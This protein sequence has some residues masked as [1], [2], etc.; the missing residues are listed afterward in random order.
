MAEKPVKVE[1]TVECPAC[2]FSYKRYTPFQTLVRAC[3]A[4]SAPAPAPVGKQTSPKGASRY[5]P[6]IPTGMVPKTPHDEATAKKAGSSSTVE[7]AAAATSEGGVSPPMATPPPRKSPF[8]EAAAPGGEEVPVCFG[9]REV[10]QKGNFCPDCG[11]FQKCFSRVLI[12]T[13][14]K[15][16]K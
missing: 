5:I 9:D 11:I 14:S 16:V 2:K 12:M 6:K 13:L 7:T 15:L 8:K 1:E 10:F 4:C 3:P